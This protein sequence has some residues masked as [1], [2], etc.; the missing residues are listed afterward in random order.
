MNL[1]HFYPKSQEDRR[2]LGEFYDTFH[3]QE[4]F[5][6]AELHENHPTQMRKAIEATVRY[7]PTLEM[8]EILQWAH[9]YNLPIEWQVLG[10]K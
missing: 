10:N 3:R 5:E 8:K 6:R 7:L 4:W 2:V 9:K 1:P